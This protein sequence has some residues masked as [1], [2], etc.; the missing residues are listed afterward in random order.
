MFNYNACLSVQQAFKDSVMA[1]ID[2]SFVDKAPEGTTVTLTR[3]FGDLDSNNPS[4]AGMYGVVE[5][6]HDDPATL[7]LIRQ[8][9]IENNYLEEG[10]FDD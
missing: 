2:D 9:L 8:A 7:A 6:H 5:I 10:E 4:H 3:N 1:D